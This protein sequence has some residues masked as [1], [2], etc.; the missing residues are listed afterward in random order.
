MLTWP[1]MWSDRNV[2]VPNGEGSG[3]TGCGPAITAAVS[4]WCLV[5]DVA[6]VEPK[7]LRTRVVTTTM[8][9]MTTMVVAIGA[10]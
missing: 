8:M 1:Q 9:V 4:H 5:H 7:R 2:P 6:V 10:Q 3:K